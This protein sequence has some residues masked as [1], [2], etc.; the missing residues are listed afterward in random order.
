MEK[1][2]CPNCGNDDIQFISNVQSKNRGCLSWLFW[3]LIWI[4]IT[5]ITIGIGLI[6]LVFIVLTNKK[7]LTRTRAVCKHCGHQWD[8]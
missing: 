2:K 4:F 8:I 7:T 6:F 5:V 3:I 1:I